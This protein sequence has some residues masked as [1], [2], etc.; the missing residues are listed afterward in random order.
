L[1]RQHRRRVGAGI[2]TLTGAWLLWSLMPGLPVL[3]APR[4]R[5]EVRQAGLE[6]FVHEWRPHDPMAHGDGLGPVYNANSCVS[7]HFQGGVGGGGSPKENVVA[8]EALPTPAR[9]VVQAGLVHKFAVEEK[10]S[11]R[12][13]VLEALFPTV[14]NGLTLRGVCFTERRDFNPVRTQRINSIALFGAGWIDRLSAKAITHQR[15]RRS[16]SAIG[17]EITGDFGS[18]PAG[19]PRILPDGRV[20]KFGWKAQF[21]TLEEFVAAACAN[22]IG[23]GTPGLAQAKPLSCRTSS[24]PEA[25]P[26][27]DKAQFRALV[28]FVTTLPR[29]R[30]VLP[31]DPH[32]RSEVERGK[33]V[34]EKVGCAA[35]HTPE[36]GG[37]A[38]VYSDFLLHRIVDSRKNYAEIADVPLPSD[39]P[40]P[41]EWKTPPLWGVADSAP[42]FHDGG[43]PTLESAILRHEADA[44]GVTEAYRKLSSGDREAVLR[45]LESLKA[46]D[47]APPVPSP[48]PAGT[49][50]SVLALAR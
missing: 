27:L 17:K 6:L 3:R 19:R 24:G 10:F 23:L 50:R 41:E 45:F 46:P 1:L 4:A 28:A 8:F 18:I 36:L 40:L 22:E 47:D 38:G 48:A 32:A 49:P 16:M 29:P 13:Q 12:P 31:D 14:P 7:C 2:L 42:Y 37:V 43:S 33:L 39:H 9:P 34:F 35:C 21:A 30:E 5:A 25:A 11:E 20:G 15:L 44:Q 26:D